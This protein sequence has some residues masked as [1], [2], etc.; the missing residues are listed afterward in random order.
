VFSLGIILYEAIGRCRLFNYD[1]VY[2]NLLAIT[3]EGAIPPPSALNKDIPPELDAVV[4]QALS[5]PLDARFQSAR[6]LQ[7]ALEAWLRKSSDAPGTFEISRTLRGLFAERIAK[8]TKL[9]ESAQ[10]GDTAPHQFAQQIEE[11]HGTQPGPSDPRGPPPSNLGAPARA[12][13][14]EEGLATSLGVPIVASEA[15]RTSL[16]VP[17]QTGAQ[18]PEESLKTS[19]GVPVSEAPIELRPKDPE[20]NLRTSLGVPAQE[21]PIESLKTRL[22]TPAQAP[23]ELL[24]TRIAVPASEAPLRPAQPMAPRM[25][26]S[27]VPVVSRHVSARTRA[28]LWVVGTIDVMAVLGIGTFL[29]LR[30]GTTPPP[31]RAAVHR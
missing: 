10:R 7:L 6:A 28:R 25:E 22:G 24:R 27:R 8:R 30:A 17:A 9:I 19:L 29:W 14:P 4:G 21:V 13:D 12:A 2:M 16:G 31:P 18:D 26:T 20:E 15:L 1:D 23:I 11:S 5:R 3:G